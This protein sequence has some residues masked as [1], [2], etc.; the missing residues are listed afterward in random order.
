MRNIY[1]LLLLSAL[2]IYGINI[3]AQSPNWGINYIFSYDSLQGFSESA[4]KSAALANGIDAD[5]IK[6]YMYYQKRA[7]IDA[8]YHLNVTKQIVEANLIQ[9][10]TTSPSGNTD[11]KGGGGGIMAAPCVNEGFELNSIAGWTLSLGTNT[12]TCS[13]VPTPTAAVLGG[14]VGAMMTTPF[15][16]PIVGAVGASPFAGNKVVKLNDGTPTGDRSVV[17]LQQT[18]NVTSTNFLYEFAYIAI[19]QNTTF[20]HGCC[21]QPFMYVRVK[22][23]LGNL[24]LCPTFSIT[25]PNGASCLGTG[26]TSWTSYTIGGVVWKA[27]ST[28]Q[29][30]SI[31]LTSYMTSCVTIE[32]TVGDCAF[33]GHA[34]YSYFDSNCNTFGITVNGNVISAPSI[35]VNATAPCGTTATLT[36]PNGLNPY[37]WD[38]PPLS[39]VSNATTQ[40][41]LGSVAGNYTIQMTPVGVCNPIYRVVNL[42]F[43]PPVTITAVPSATI[44]SGNSTTLQAAGATNYTWSPGGQTTSSIVVSP[45]TTTIYTV[46][47]VSG[48]CSGTFTFQVTVNSALTVTASATPTSICSSGGSSTLTA[49]GATSYTWMPGGATT[50]SIVVSPTTTTIYTV[51]GSTGA[52]CSASTTVVLTVNSTPTV[53]AF[54]NPASI[55]PGNT[56]TLTAF[57]AS[58]YTWNPGALTGAFVTVNPTVTTT[59]TVTG[60]NAG[61]TG[62]TTAMVTVNPSPTITA[63]ASPTGICSG[64]SATLTASGAVNY[65]W[66]PGGS[67]TS[68][69]VVSP[70]V[71]T[72]YTVTGNS[73]AGCSASVAVTL[74]VTTTPTIT[75]SASPATICAGSS[76]TLSAVG[77]SSYTWNPGG[78]NGANV[79]VSP[80][81]TTTYTVVGSNGSCLGNTVT[82]ALVVN[83]SP[84]VTAS[85]SPTVICSGSS[86]TLTASGATTYTWNPGAL[87]GVT[88]SV[89]PAS[90]TQYTVSGTSAGCTATAVV[91]VSVNPTPT[92]TASASP[93]A[94]CIGSSSTLTA[95]GAANYTWMPGGATTSS[96]VVSP[97]ITTIYTITGA[98]GSCTSTQTIQLLVN[99]I[100]TVTAVS[101]PTA[102]CAGATATLTGSGALTYTWNP[103][104]LVGTT[105]TVSPAG[106]T[107]YTVTGS[108]GTC[109]STAT[110]ALVV[111]PNPT[112]TASASPTN[113]CS[114]TSST[115]TANGALTYTWNPG[116]LTGQTVS[117]SP[118][119]TTTYTVTGSNAFGCTASATVVLV[120]TPTPTVTASVNPTLICAGSSATLTGSGATTYTWLPGGMTTATAVVN[121]TVTTTY[122]L[123]GANGGFCFNTQTVMLTVNP[124]PTVTAV[125]NPTVICSGSS[126]TLTGS[127]ALTYTWMPGGMNTFSVVVSPTTTT[128]YTLTGA[129]GVGCTSTVAVTLSVTPTPTLT[130]TASPTA[131]CVGATATLTGSGATSYTWS[132]GGLNTSTIAVSPTV[133]TT[134]T[135]DGA[136]GS[137]IT[138]QTISLIVNGLPTITAVAAPTVICS[139][140]TSTLTGSG[141]VTYTW[142]PG[143]MTTA[144]AVVNPT[145]STTYTLTGASA[146]GCVSTVTTALTVNPNPTLTLSAS[147]ASIC[148]AGSVTLTA[149][150][151]TNY[152]WNP[153]GMS[154]GTVVVNPT[155]TTTYSVTGDN[156]FGCTTTA[157]L[158]VIV[159][160]L[161]FT[162]AT[163]NPTLVCAGSTATLTGSGATTYTWNPGGLTGTS[164][165][166]APVANTN[167]TVTGANGAC[168]STAVVSVS[169]NPTPTLTASAS[170][171][172]IC[173]G[174]SSTLTASGALTYT[175]NPGA[176]SGGTVVVSPVIST[177]YVVSGKPMAGFVLVRQ[178]LL[179]R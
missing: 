54:S 28:W 45:T 86:A 31:D 118:V 27:N 157:T 71:T 165:T 61:C 16:D 18:F 171:T 76:S 144:T 145:V 37:D 94:I 122:T 22:D 85:A 96:I 109:G 58:T 98:N 93:T 104:G 110:V 83:P 1:K 36:A 55:C 146:A 155:I 161:S 68:S 116:A 63:V 92:I 48:T 43:T 148:V 139:G 140:A 173:S 90:T 25:P 160:T 130:T 72:T 77:A 153:G 79:T 11:L 15:V 168:T 125:S 4:I 23:C 89:S 149:T 53:V 3:K 7:F 47:A 50:S 150:G 13:H 123:T 117:V 65:T 163:A 51:T 178:L 87:N 170:P 20:G 101:N 91:S 84:T 70:G 126:A 26:P 166:V 158:A 74:S 147:A 9:L 19:N 169:V 177:T 112:V 29:K 5:D 172:V 135:L 35:T 21:D 167:Y 95:V 80:G 24:L 12:S 39:G 102:I 159:N 131:I 42:T 34:G 175:W 2:L 142:M 114:G 14:T 99:P 17:R 33:G 120:V 59:Y 56:A 78:L 152:T 133:T 119:L 57:G 62:T 124:I 108:N 127:G 73:G 176:L 46:A 30:Y 52:T 40:T 66:M 121:P 136:N 115:L 41:I 81:T 111:N 49:G 10:P 138:T 100:P 8:K 6:G 88:V 105:V 107:T 106:N 134:Y 32:V 75:A 97:A 164:V 113:I 128:T 82:V 67:L 132:P 64:S 103:G 38:G 141:A 174:G 143:G 156:A 151:A 44:C 129:N 179:Y 154:G 60:A 69:I 162:S 137:C